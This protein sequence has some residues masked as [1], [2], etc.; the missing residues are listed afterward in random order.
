MTSKTMPDWAQPGT[1][2]LITS[3][4]SARATRAKVSRVTDASVFVTSDAWREGYE[5]RFVPVRTQWNSASVS[6]LEEYGRGT[7]GFS[8]AARCV[9]ADGDE[10]KN[11]LRKSLIRERQDLAIAAAKQFTSYPTKA[12]AEAARQRIADWAQVTP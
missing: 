12:N 9:P 8:A 3:R 2:V 11:I 4:D 10:G 6:A 7:N 5:R 1:E